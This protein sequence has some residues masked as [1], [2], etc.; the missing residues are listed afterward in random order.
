MIKFHPYSILTGEGKVDFL[1]Y[2]M[3]RVLFDHW[4]KLHLGLDALSYQKILKGIYSS[5]VDDNQDS[6]CW[7][8]TRLANE[9]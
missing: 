8:A 2:G 1:I 3:L 4:P 5:T 9:V 6:I 7:A